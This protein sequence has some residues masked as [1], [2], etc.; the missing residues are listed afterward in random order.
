MLPVIPS[1][2]VNKEK[3]ILLV[4][5][6]LEAASIVRELANYLPGSAALKTNETQKTDSRVPNRNVIQK[7]QP[8]PNYRPVQ[9]VRRG[10]EA[11]SD[12]FVDPGKD[13]DVAGL[14]KA[15]ETIKLK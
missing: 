7:V 14:A 10:R 3:Q 1:I 9:Q 15:V 11:D 4:S 6:T 8:K 12:E 13:L 5:K 2:P